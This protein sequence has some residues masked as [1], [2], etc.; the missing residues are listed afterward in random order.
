[1]ANVGRYL[2]GFTD[3]AFRPAPDVRGLAGAPIQLIVYNDIAAVVSPHPVARLMPS[4]GNVEPH[5]RVVRSVSQ[6]ARLVPAAFGHV[7]DCEE[8]IA[9][10]LRANQYEIRQE[11]DRL[12]RTCEMTLKMWWNVDNLFNLLV[13]NN[14]ALRDLRD[15]VFRGGEPSLN[16]KLQVGS[17]FEATLAQERE[18][19]TARLLGAFEGITR[20]VFQSPPRDEKAICQA[21]L[22]VERASVSEFEPAVRRAATLFDATFALDYGG[23]WPP[24]SFVRLRLQSVAA[25][26]AV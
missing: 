4:R 8:D 23:P 14:Q 3:S 11:L 24:Y 20:D 18:R 22:L 12:G 6:E 21:A 5:H 13:R 1:M 17:A 16:D 9:R 2:Y 26:A 10:V 15:R 25:P 19:L 7:S